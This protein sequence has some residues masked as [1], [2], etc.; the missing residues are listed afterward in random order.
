[1]SPNSSYS[2][3]VLYKLDSFKK[4]FVDQFQRYDRQIAVN[5]INQKGYEAPLGLA[6]K[7]KSEEL[8][9]PR[10]R[11]VGFDFREHCR[12]MKWDKISLLIDE[13][14]DDLEKQQ[15]ILRERTTCEG[16]DFSLAHKLHGLFGSHQRGTKPPC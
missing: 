6:F 13:I 10:L 2:F 12:K 8:G 15:D 16:T 7:A 4:H 14:L 1:M 9:D 11:Y 3:I 5:L